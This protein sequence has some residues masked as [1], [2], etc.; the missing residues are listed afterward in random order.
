MARVSCDNGNP[1][2]RSVAAYHGWETRLKP[3]KHPIAD[4]IMSF[5]WKEWD[6]YSG[7]HNYWIRQVKKHPRR[8]WETWKK[9]AL[10]QE[11]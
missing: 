5:L 8:S 11:D 10:A 3:R 1:Y 7:A 6:D 4:R 2:S 9:A